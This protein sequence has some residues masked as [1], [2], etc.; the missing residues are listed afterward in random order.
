M[1]SE[2]LG[3][4]NIARTLAAI[5]QQKAT[6]ELTLT[7][8]RNQHWKFYFF[9]G[10]LVYGT[11]SLHRVRRFYRVVK[12]HNSSFNIQVL[13]TEEPWEYQLLSSGV[14]SQQFSVEQAKAV[15]Q[16]S[17]QEVLF[18]IVS[19]S[20]LTSDWCSS[21]K[22][23]SNHNAG[24]SLLLSA[25]QVERVLQQAQLLWRQ[26]QAIGLG[27]ISPYMAPFLKASLLPNN[28]EGVNPPAALIPFLQGQY[29]LW[30]IASQA[31][32]PVTTVVRFLLPWVQKGVLT[33]QEVS[34]LPLPKQSS[35]EV[36]TSKPL[37]AC[38]DDSPL[39]GRILA[40][41]LIPAGYRLLNIQD[42]LSGIATLVKHK[43]NL[44][45]LDLNMPDTSGYNLCS[46]LR[47][48]QAFE[49]IPII[50][51]TGQD[52]ILDRTRAK[53]AGASDFLSKPPDPHL[54]LNLVQQHVKSNQPGSSCL[55][56]Q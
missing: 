45:F 30:D 33:L 39:V 40:D 11:G 4:V 21:Q 55:V 17:L 12:R 8:N 19:N 26:W 2:S 38:I 20:T 22:F 43:P 34:D 15:S 5:G 9:H 52:G 56:A 24:L 50:I 29:T 48:T 49:R 13:P 41:I 32:K 7:N 42:P 31:Q 54:L 10:R 18:S 27:E 3:Y 23:S 14:S 47:K 6:G 53:L 46:F 51:L 35:I 1:S 37:I 44:L 16:T 25:P 28:S 36:A